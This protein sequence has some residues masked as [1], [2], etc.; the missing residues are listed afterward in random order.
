MTFVLFILLV[1]KF[2][3]LQSCGLFVFLYHCLIRVCLHFRCTR[4][5]FLREL[6]LP[7]RF[8][9]NFDSVGFSRIKVKE[10]WKE[11]FE[12]YICS[13]DFDTF[14]DYEKKINQIKLR[15]FFTLHSFTYFFYFLKSNF[16]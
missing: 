1:K 11:K 12:K 5:S 14:P 7:N 9:K 10:Y 15:L 16:L 13:S 4:E 2:S 3:T 8:Q 6:K